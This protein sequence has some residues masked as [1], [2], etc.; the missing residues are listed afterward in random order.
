MI[1]YD[2]PPPAK[3]RQ[4]VLEILKNLFQEVLKPSE[5]PGRRDPAN[6]TKKPGFP[7]LDLL[8]LYMRYV[9]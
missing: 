1:Q 4:E 3:R 7:G 6:G 5:T 2:R 8:H 9:R